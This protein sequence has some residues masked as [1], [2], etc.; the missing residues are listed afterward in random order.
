MGD[1]E[2]IGDLWLKYL[3]DNGLS[4]VIRLRDNNYNDAINATGKPIEKIEKKKKTKLDKYFQR[5]L[6]LMVN[7]ISLFLQPIKIGMGK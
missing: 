7:L 2:Y 5:I 6:N 4:F 1:R 3:K